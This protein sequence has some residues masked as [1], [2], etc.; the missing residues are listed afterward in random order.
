MVEMKLLNSMCMPTECDVIFDGAGW[1]GFR[2]CWGYIEDVC[3]ACCI[4]SIKP[5]DSEDGSVPLE[6]ISM[7]LRG[8]LDR[9][10]DNV[11]AEES[12]NSKI[13]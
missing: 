11:S 7:M 6:D 12:K 3:S 8:R 9:Y 4:V 1:Y 13:L 2:L 10:A 5:V